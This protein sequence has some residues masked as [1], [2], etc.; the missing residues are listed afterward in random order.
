[1]ATS[2]ALSMQV[3]ANTQGLA[4]AT[5][6]VEKLMNQMEKSVKDTQ[7]QLSQISL[8]TGFQAAVVAGQ[9]FVRVV[10]RVSGALGSLVQAT[11]DQENELI[12]VQ[13]VFGEA[14][15]AIEAF[16]KT[17]TQ[18][19]ISEVQALRAAGSFGNL[20]SAL[21]STDDESAQL[22]KTLTLLAADLAAFSNTSID[23]ALNAIQ[24]GLQGQTRP[25]RAFQVNINA[26]ML[27]T[28]AF[29]IGLTDTV[30]KALT[31]YQRSLATVAV[32]LEQTENAQGQAVREADQYGT[33]LRRVA[34]EISDVAGTLGQV[35]LPIFKAVSQGFLNALPGIEA[36][37]KRL[38]EAFAGVDWSLLGAVITGVIDGFVTFASV[39]AD[40]LIPVIAVLGSIISPVVDL[41]ES[42]GLDAEA[43]S[44]IIKGAFVG[45]MIGGAVALVVFNSAAIVAAVT[46][47]PKLVMSII[48]LQAAIPGWGWVIAGISALGALAALLWPT[49]D[50]KSAADMVDETKKTIEE[51][52]GVINEAGAQ[53]SAAR[54]EIEKPF[55]FKIETFNNENVADSISKK[56]VQQFQQLAVGV[57]GIEKILFGTRKKYEELIAAQ[58]EYNESPSTEGL[59]RVLK[60][61]EEL[62]EE[63][64]KQT[65]AME[66]Q[67]KA[68]EAAAKAYQDAL[69]VVDGLVDDSLTPSQRAASEYADR[70]EAISLTLKTAQEKLNEARASGDAKA[71]AD[72]QK[73]LEI[74]KKN[75][76]IAA[77]EAEKQ[78][79]ESYLEGMGFNMDDFKKQTSEIE[80]LSL[81]VQEFNRG[82]LTG[83]E[84]RN[85]V[86]N[87]ASGVVEWFRQ[88]KEQT[89]EI[90]DENLKAMDT[91]TAEGLE[92]FFRLATGQTDPALEAE[93]E[94]VAQ[95]KKIN[96]Q[97]KGTGLSVATIAGY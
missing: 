1:M 19:G 79:R 13:A 35:F 77:G 14:S 91:R 34:A 64:K 8:F 20:F 80:R 66:D 54:K 17:T 42:F 63:V 70:M 94:Q 72:A 59:Q 15:A 69:K 60:L 53:A 29:E 37:A 58:K 85:Y 32:L 93:R 86:E 36:F 10:Q 25:L 2:L 55:Q 57:G 48:A 22:S 74:S 38:S 30:T 84:V 33:I 78:R 31:P 88:I 75:A 6:D 26:A 43:I 4:K 68:I 24:S 18:L 76:D 87:T 96:K 39:V 95:L 51:T 50:G 47:I 46:A 28:K 16:A 90:A 11:A 65:Q 49:G 45:A 71:I 56:A 41:F 83:A 97:L 9:Q 92:E 21:G 73:L 67:K 40:I 62:T 23:Q 52:L 89:Q 5:K 7:K 12:R 61:S 44:K 82:I 3:T 27:Q 81:V